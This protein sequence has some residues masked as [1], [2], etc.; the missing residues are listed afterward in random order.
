V[1]ALRDRRSFVLVA[2]PGAGKTTRVPRALLDSGVTTGMILVLEPRRLAARLSAERVAAE[3]GQKVGDSVGF[4]TRFERATSDNTRIL[5]VTEGILGRRLLSDPTLEG[6]GV[7]LFD[8]FHERHMASDMGLAMLKRLVLEKRSDLGIGAMS[9][10]LDAGPLTTFL[11]APLIT[12]KGRAFPVAIAHQDKPDDR[13]L[14]SQ[15]ASA[16]FDLVTAGLDGHVLVFLPGSREIRACEESLGKLR[17]RHDLAVLPLFGSQSARDQDRAVL[18]SER[19]KI[20][21]ATNVAETSITIDGV[22]AVIDSGLANVASCS[23]WTGMPALKQSK[24]SKASATQRA[25]RAGRTRAGTCFRLYTCGDFAARAA[26]DKPEIAR[27]DLAEPALELVASGVE[28]L[29]SFDWFEAPSPAALDGAVS[30]LRSLHAVQGEK[31]SLRITETGTRMLSFPVHPR[32]ARLLVEAERRG[33][34]DSGAAIAAII[35]ERPFTSQQSG[36][37]LSSERSDLVA[38]LDALDEAEHLG[39]EAAERRGIDR[40]RATAVL[41][42]RDQLRRIARS[43]GPSPA[44]PELHEE[45]LL[46]AILSAYPDRVG[47]L[48]RADAQLGRRSPEIVFAYGTSAVLDESSRVREVDL[49]VAIDAEERSVGGRMKAWVRLASAIEADWLLDMFT[50]QIIDEEVIS[51]SESSG[52][53]EATRVMRF[54]SLVLEEERRPVTDSNKA[55]AALARAAVARGLSPAGLEALQTIGERL[56]LARGREPA[57]FAELALEPTDIEAVTRVAATGCASLSELDQKNLGEL[58]LTSLTNAQQ[59][60]LRALTPERIE[61]GSGRSLAVAYKPGSPPSIAARLQDFFGS[62]DG[63]R[64]L[65]GSLPLVLELLAP[66]QRAVQVTT[67]LAGF[68]TKHYPAIAK[69][70][71]RKYPR[72]SWPDDPLHAEPQLRPSPRKR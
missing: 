10:T 60:A 33:V 7:V 50:D 62:A 26:F 64:I 11:D 12:S 42:V 34:A 59:Q 45:A 61:L 31:G 6:V 47:R 44:S 71:R 15:V 16:V 4:V 66:N 57:T 55:T 5:F 19:R 43:R 48:K 58:V 23:P 1:S 32:Q 49:L 68:W 25:G 35:G 20:I 38:L 67:D 54:G 39:R 27:M 18:P 69:E 36:K 52:R 13:P 2:E 24:I 53:V 29:D 65:R 30:L 51:V 72:H 3:L 28:S 41:R 46:K 21:L 9:A 14:S 63:P 8:E 17:E 40:L 70:L 56:A 37:R 22:V